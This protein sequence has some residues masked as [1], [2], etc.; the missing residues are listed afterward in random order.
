MKRIVTAALALG[1]L[2]L[3]ASAVGQSLRVGSVTDTR[4][5]DSWTLDGPEMANTRAKLLNTANFGA[6]GTVSKAIAITDT[7]GTVGSVTG[8][9]LANF[10][11]FFIG[12]LD[13]ANV[14]AFTPAELSAMQA[15]VN[16]GG[17]NHHV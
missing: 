5:G 9:L 4:F 11:V 2:A 1:M 10:D 8:S 15:W 6:G 16:G 12:Y 13:D 17:T 14:N 7:A 3:C